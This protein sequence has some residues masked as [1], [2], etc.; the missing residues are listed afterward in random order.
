MGIGCDTAVLVERAAGGA[1]ARDH[2]VALPPPFLPELRDSAAARAVA[3]T[4]NVTA[5]FRLPPCTRVQRLHVISNRGRFYDLN[6][7]ALRTRVTVTK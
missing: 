4:N 3:P 5:R 2:T 6:A 7:E 1:V